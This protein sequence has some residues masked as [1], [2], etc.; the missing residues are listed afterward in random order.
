MKSDLS[1]KC[2]YFVR[3]REIILIPLGQCSNDD[4][5][6]TIGWVA[7]AIAAVVIT[8]EKWLSTKNFGTTVV[9]LISYVLIQL[10]LHNAPI[11]C[12]VDNSRKSDTKYIE[13]TQTCFC[14]F[15][16][17]L[18]LLIFLQKKL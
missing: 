11:K 12:V 4:E 13:I 17:L 15:F 16:F 18:Y 9:T 1:R 3:P 14:A 10:S 7:F 6:G 5:D 8:V 2:S